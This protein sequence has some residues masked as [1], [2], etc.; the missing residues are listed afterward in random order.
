MACAYLHPWAEGMLQR[1]EKLGFAARQAVRLVLHDC[2]VPGAYAMRGRTW[3][4]HF[5]VQFCRDNT[6][7]SGLCV[8]CAGSTER[9][10]RHCPVR[11]E[12][13]M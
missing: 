3:Y 4:T 12:A 1:V 6:Q 2:N 5:C 13:F 11:Q 9:V 7:W 8:A 10:Q